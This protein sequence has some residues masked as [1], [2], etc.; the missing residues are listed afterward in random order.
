MYNEKVK[1]LTKPKGKDEKP[2]EVYQDPKAGPIVKGLSHTVVTNWE[3]V[4]ALLQKGSMVRATGSTA[5]NDRSSRSHALVQ[6][7][8]SQ[9]EVIGT[10]GKK[11]IFRKR[12][13]RINLVDLAGSEKISKSKVEGVGLTEATNINKSLTTLGRIIDAL[14]DHSPY[15]PYRDSVLTMLLSDSLGGNARTTMLA[16]LSPTWNNFEETLSTLRYASRAR[17]VVNVVKVC[18]VRWQAF[19]WR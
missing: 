9:E 16:T 3:Q 14:I 11:D 4:T 19:W 10:V 13:S 15:V 7:L 18:V 12:S 17:K 5:M 6:L 1:D 8:L 2:L